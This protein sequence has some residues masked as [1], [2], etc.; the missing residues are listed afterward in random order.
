MAIVGSPTG[1]KNQ[2]RPRW[3]RVL[4]IVAGCYVGVILVLLALENSLVFHPTRATEEWLA[5]PDP[6]IQDIDLRTDDGRLIHAWW[7]PGAPEAGALVYCHGNAGNVSL[8]GPEMAS[9][10]RE[11]NMGV[12]L[13]DYPGYGKSEGTPAEAAC[14]AA[15]QAA[16]NW[17]REHAGIAEHQIIIQGRS[18][19]AAVAVELASR[20]PHRA[21]ILY[22]AFTSIPDMAQRA[23]PW[24]PARWLVRNRFDNL[25]KIGRCSSPIFIAHG[26]RDSVVPFTHGQRLFAVA[27]APKHF[28]AMAGFDHDE[29]PDQRFFAT[30]RRFLAES[31]ANGSLQRA[32]MHEPD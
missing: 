11:L 28:H 17:L 22:S 9:W 7:W 3:R 2:R 6:S 5:P 15:A 25:E 24:L 14:Y 21:L 29:G 16:Y 13:F 30:P 8:W 18:L 19:G 31:A 27:R 10:R 20:C 26:D 23:F 1:T 4:A 12:L 32:K